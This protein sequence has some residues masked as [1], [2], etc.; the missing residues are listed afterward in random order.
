MSLGAKAI[1]AVALVAAAFLC[2]FLAVQ[3]AE[4]GQTTASPAA[5]SAVSASGAGAARARTDPADAMIPVAPEVI[6]RLADLTFPDTE[7][8]SI[9]YYLLAEGSGKK[10]IGGVAYNSPTYHNVTVKGIG[11][12]KATAMEI[13]KVQSG[14]GLS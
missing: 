10:T 8:H 1:L 4:A 7:V 13:V 3:A 12:T 11:R 14:Q 2:G 6:V 9:A 5:P